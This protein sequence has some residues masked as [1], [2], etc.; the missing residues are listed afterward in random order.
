M[1]FAQRNQAHLDKIKDK[2]FE[3]N[4][5]KELEHQRVSEAK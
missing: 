2:R 1:S 5:L 3:E 4:L